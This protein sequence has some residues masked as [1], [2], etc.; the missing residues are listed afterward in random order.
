MPPPRALSLSSALSAR[1]AAERDAR[2]LARKVQLLQV[3]WLGRAHAHVSQAAV[4]S[5]CRPDGLSGRKG[6]G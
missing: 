3:P 5:T 2:E 1:E 4:P 6:K